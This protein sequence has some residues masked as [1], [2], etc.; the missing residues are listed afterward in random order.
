MTE[1]QVK[2]AFNP[3][4]DIYKVNVTKF[5]LAIFKKV[6]EEN[7]TAA[8]YSPD[9]NGKRRY[10]KAKARFATQKHVARQRILDEAPKSPLV[11]QGLSA[12][13]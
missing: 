1:A 7:R 6:A 9:W 11:T 3:N 5:A 10:G 2:K 12:L 4:L 8:S 13:D